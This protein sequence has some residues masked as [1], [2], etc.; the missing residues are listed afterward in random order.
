VK[1]CEVA[2]SLGAISVG[3]ESPFREHGRRGIAIVG[4]RYQETS[5]E[6]AAGWK[7]LSVIW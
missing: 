5:S 3:R 1:R 7:K 4:S 6:D 2:A